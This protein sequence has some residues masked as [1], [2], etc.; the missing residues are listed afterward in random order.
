MWPEEALAV[1]GAGRCITG[2]GRGRALV[3]KV[4][5]EPTA[6]ADADAGAEAAVEV[7]R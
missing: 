2:G 1:G 6:T 3:A 4:G 7:G 5:G